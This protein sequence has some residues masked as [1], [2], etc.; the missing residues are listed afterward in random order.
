M[1]TAIDNS[2]TLRSTVPEINA[3]TLSTPDNERMVRRYVAALCQRADAV[4]DLTQEV[5]LRA[6]ERVDRV[7][8]AAD[9]PRFLRGIARKI[10]QE[11]FRARRRDSRHVALTAEALVGDTRPPDARCADA[12]ALDALRDAIADLPIVARRMLEMR[13]HDGRNA[14]QIAATLDI[15]AAAVRMSLMRIRQ[16]L[17]RTIGEHD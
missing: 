13:Y 17:R 1:L 6:I 3:L 7:R 9:A 2:A 14:T 16:R 12:A 4:D 10:V 11:H 5:F 15:D 8:S